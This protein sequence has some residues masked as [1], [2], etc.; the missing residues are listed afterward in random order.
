MEE[1][2]EP[3]DYMPKL[4]LLAE[5]TEDHWNLFQL[6][7]QR[8]GLAN[9]LKVLHDGDQVITYLRGIG[10][11]ADRRRR[12]LPA[13]LFLDLRLPRVSGFEVL[14][15]IGTQPHLA[16]MLVIA[17]SACNEMEDV[18]QAYQLGAR[19]FI[20]KP[21]T[22]PELEGVIKSFPGPW[23]RGVGNP[24]P[25]TPATRRVETTPRKLL[26]LVAE[27]SPDDLHF[28]RKALATT[29][30]LE[31]VAAVQDGD[32]AIAYF[33][34]KGRFA[35]R[36]RFPLPHVLFVDLKMPRVN[37]LQV[38]EWLQKNRFQS[39]TVVMLTGS[40]SGADYRRACDLGVDAFHVKPANPNDLTPL[41]RS[42][43]NLLVMAAQTR[44]WETRGILKN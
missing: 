23:E 34:G 14:K 32:E 10:E 40:A 9:P 1:R 12:P 18:R 3:T 8:S 17:L 36:G 42:L 20:T 6:A 21:I 2:A 13:V 37:G 5:D 7:W 29:T 30:R 44:R 11:Y 28:L 41:V 35:D 43:E 19:T 31:L 25:V 26:V 16:G 33:E 22:L 38:I 24:E 39:L 4:V 27:D 15:W